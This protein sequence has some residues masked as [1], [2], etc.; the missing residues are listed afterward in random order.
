MK[1]YLE[2]LLA[3]PAVTIKQVI[4]QLSK[5]DQDA[6]FELMLLHVTGSL[7]KQKALIGVCPKGYQD[8]VTLAVVHVGVPSDDFN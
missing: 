3:G 2:A 4:E 8:E 7:G 6:E 1:K 5:Y